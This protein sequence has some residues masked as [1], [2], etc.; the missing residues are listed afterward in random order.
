MT[1]QTDM[2]RSDIR[3][4]DTQLQEL[5]NKG[6]SIS[7]E[8]SKYVKQI[9]DQADKL[10]DSKKQNT[11]LKKKIA[12]LEKE[13]HNLNTQF[14]T[15]IK[16]KKRVELDLTKKDTR[17]NKLSEDIEKMKV[18]HRQDKITPKMASGNDDDKGNMKLINENKKLEKQRNELL[19]AFKKQLKLIDLLKRQKT[20]LEAAQMLKF[21]EEQFIQALELGEKLK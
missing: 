10:N 4:R 1:E 17:I 11:D 8:S 3:S 9:K 18:N 15:M 2:L 5:K 19:V 12:I 13:R 21:T 7:E 16:D 20:H 6:S 14:E